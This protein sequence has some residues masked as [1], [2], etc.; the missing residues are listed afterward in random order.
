MLP[1]L[2]Y[3]PPPKP[4]E[5]ETRKSRVRLQSA[6]S[7]SDASDTEEANESGAPAAAPPP[8]ARPALPPRLAIEGADRKPPRRPGVLSQGTLHVLL[9]AQ[10][11]AR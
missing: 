3:M 7:I 2:I 10:E 4:K 8:A 1:P 6:G 11:V 5:I 9:G